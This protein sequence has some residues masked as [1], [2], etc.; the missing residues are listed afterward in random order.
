[1]GCEG[2][3]VK[4]KAEQPGAEKAAAPAFPRWE[5]AAG[6]TY[7]V[8]ELRFDDDFEPTV[9]QQTVSASLG[10]SFT[11][12]VSLRLSLGGVADGSI[13]GEG[14]EHDLDSGFTGG[15]QLAW[16]M[17]EQNEY[18]PYVAGTLGLA[19]ARLTT[20]ERPALAL[21]EHAVG[22][23][24]AAMA[25]DGSTV[26]WTAVD[27]RLGLVIGYTFADLFSPYLAV[28]GFGGPVL[29][30]HLGAEVTGSD[31]HHYQGA[32]GF[33]ILLEAGMSLYFDGSF[34]GERSASAGFSAAF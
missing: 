20:H 33:A 27:I 3:A 16:R 18:T 29:W 30:S 6:Y 2:H 31:R 22:P 1:M 12:T 34:L 14:E 13:R 4:A 28:R 8:S 9:R 32:A 21:S 23:K 7:S 10:Y 19:V 26:D 24:A 5:V 11:S 15:L 25:G 17:V